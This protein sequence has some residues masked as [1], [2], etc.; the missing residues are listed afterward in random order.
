[1]GG[2]ATGSGCAE[3]DEEPVVMSSDRTSLAGAGVGAKRS[4]LDGSGGE[5]DS[6]LGA[7]GVRA[8][9]AC[10]FCCGTDG[11]EF[12]SVTVPPSAERITSPGTPMS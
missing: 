4:S 8:D 5:A 1:M 6:S 11:E 10:G 3:E 9:E 12:C 7:E 2:D